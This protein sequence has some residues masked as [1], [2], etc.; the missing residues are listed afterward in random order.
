MRLRRMRRLETPLSE[1]PGRRPRPGPAD[2]EAMDLR[3]GTVLCPRNHMAIR[4][5]PRP[6]KSRRLPRRAR[7]KRSARLAEHFVVAV[8]AAFGV[9][10]LQ[11]QAGRFVVQEGIG[12]GSGETRE[13]LR[14]DHL[15]QNA[16]VR[17]GKRTTG[18][19][20][21]VNPLASRRFRSGPQLHRIR[22]C[23]YLIRIR[24]PAESGNLGS[25]SWSRSTFR[26]SVH[27]I[28]K[29]VPSPKW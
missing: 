27:T 16:T 25:G 29:S 20:S 17:C 2:A 22:A 4:R 11:V 6:R 10:R 23:A 18:H 19:T 28:H 15:A 14:N 9:L 13:D 8:A 7:L 1:R 12:H 5:P 3:Q 24:L 21:P 26:P